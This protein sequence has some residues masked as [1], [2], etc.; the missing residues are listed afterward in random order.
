MGSCSRPGTDAQG[1]E[2]TRL[3]SEVGIKVDS[4][5]A[6]GRIGRTIHA[7]WA[8]LD[9][10]WHP[11]MNIAVDHEGR[12]AAIASGVP[13][14][15]AVRAGL[16]VPGMPN[17]HCHAFQRRIAGRTE[18]ASGAHGDSFWTWRE[19]M[20]QAVEA[21]D[22]PALHA[23]ALELYRSL[24]ARGYTSVAEFHYVH[25]LGGSSAQETAAALVEAAREAGL[26]LLLLP[27]L[28]R[29]G[30]LD[31]A[32][33][34]PRQQ[35]F[36]LTLDEYGSLLQA[37]ADS[38]RGRHDLAVGIA[39]HSIRAVGAADLAEVLTLRAA[40]APGCPVHIHVSE[41]LAE[42]AAARELLGTTP[43]D[44]LC[45]NAPVDRSWVL[46][47]ATHAAPQELA[48][49]RRRGA[50]VCVCTTTEAN[51][52]DGQFDIERW[53]QLGGALAIGSDS[54]VGLDPAEELRWLEYQARLRQQRRTLLVDPG[55]AHPGTSLWRRA[56]AGG[57]QAFGHEHA[58]IAIGAPAELLE[59]LVSDPALTPDEALDDLV[60]AQRAARPGRPE[61]LSS[62]VGHQASGL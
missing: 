42:V 15:G 59:I 2:A 44:W 56:V 61:D 14:E 1:N 17:A 34:S 27:V 12:I 18:H 60:F 7:R 46:V 49:A 32:P 45:A 48:L 30:G 50:V 4:D 8:L 51:L 54:N 20:Y 26:R 40:I 28:Y 13:P 21:L 37:I 16:L 19:R 6:A 33:L 62:V 43:I 3:N 29:R 22:A 58:G 38:A 24:R 35:R 10:G 55:S 9:S 52:G 31:D 23:T 41:Q 39:P 5:Q 57:R 25:R 53:W 47:H 11:S 36:S